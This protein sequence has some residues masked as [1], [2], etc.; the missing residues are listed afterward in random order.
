MRRRAFIAAIGGA[1]AWPVMARA[2][3]QK[4]KRIGWLVNGNSSDPE[5]RSRVTALTTELEKLGWKLGTNMSIEYRWA[6]GDANLGRTYAAEL[7]RLAPDLILT[8]SVQNV[9]ALRERTHTIPI[10]FTGASDPI[11]TATRDQAVI[12]LA[13][14][15]TPKHNTPLTRNGW[16]Y[17]R[18]FPQASTEWRLSIVPQTDRGLA[19]RKLPR[20]RLPHSRC[21]YRA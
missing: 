17:S 11:A 5:Q 4:S 10:V 6:E 13:S 12:S 19:G 8:A 18:R 3:Q 21:S 9:S 7:V 20:A 14:P 2:Q 15:K 1:A 16:N